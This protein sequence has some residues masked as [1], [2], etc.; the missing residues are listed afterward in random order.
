MKNLKND[1]LPIIF[2]LIP[3]LYLISIWSSLP[4]TVPIHWNVKGEVD[5]YG[6]KN[7]L[8]ILLALL[9]YFTYFLLKIIPLIDPKNKLKNMGKKYEMLKMFLVGFMSLLATFIFYITKN[10][11]A[12]SISFVYS[13]IGL[14]F[15]ILGNYFPTIKHNYF[16]GIRTPWTLENET[17]WKQTHQMAGKYWMLGGILIIILSL[18]IDEEFMSTLFLSVTAI[19]SLTPIIYSYKI[20]KK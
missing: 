10:D 14:L 18:F 13:L 9:P 4:Q 5:N 19:I 12:V 1:I 6:S 20:S 2:I 16:I 11:T 17:V 8:I 15:I 7:M 3:T